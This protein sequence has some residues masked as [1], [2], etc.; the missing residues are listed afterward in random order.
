MVNAPFLL[1]LPLS[2]SQKYREKSGGDL[3]LISAK[4]QLLFTT[5]FNL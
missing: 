5:F 3:I 1:L 4:V 2:A